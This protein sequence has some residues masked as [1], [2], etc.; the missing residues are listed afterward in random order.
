M[1]AFLGIARGSTEVPW[2]L[3]MRLNM[4]EGEGHEEGPDGKGPIALV[5]KGETERCMSEGGGYF[6][7]RF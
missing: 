1:G 3:E 4:P 5:G 6:E 2:L 7:C